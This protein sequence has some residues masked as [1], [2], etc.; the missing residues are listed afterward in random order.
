MVESELSADIFE[1]MRTYL[2]SD[3]NTKNE[4][5]HILCMLMLFLVF[6]L[7]SNASRLSLLRASGME[8]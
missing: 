5:M 6:A 1:I 2:Y 8:C 4:S 3:L 7:I